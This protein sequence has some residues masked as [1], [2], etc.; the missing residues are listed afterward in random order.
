MRIGGF[1]DL[2]DFYF[3]ELRKELLCIGCHPFVARLVVSVVLAHH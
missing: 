2:I 3:L 1:A